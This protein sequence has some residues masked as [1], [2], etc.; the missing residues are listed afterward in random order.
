MKLRFISVWICDFKSFKGSHKFPLDL[1]VGVHFVR[2]RNKD[3]KRLGSNGSGKSS[4]WDAITWCLFGRTPAGLKNPDVI[5]WGD[6]KVGP[7]VKLTIKVD[8]THYEIMRTAKP[9][10]LQ[11]DG[12]DVG[13]EAIVQLIGMSFEVMTNTIILGQEQPLFF[14]R[15]ASEKMALLS[16]V[17]GLERWD[18]RSK[19]ASAR[20][21]ELDAELVVYQREVHGLESSI[22]EL[23]M[24]TKTLTD[25]SD[26]WQV[27]FEKAEVDTD[28]RERKLNTARDTL[29]HLVDGLDLK[30]D[31][32]MT[33]VRSLE[34]EVGKLSGQRSNAQTALFTCRARREQ[35]DE[36]LDR[37]EDELEGLERSPRCPTC[38][39]ALGK[40]VV[41]DMRTRKRDVLK[42]LTAERNELGTKKLNSE[43]EDT[44][45]R[46]VSAQSYLD[47]FHAT[48]EA[49]LREHKAQLDKLSDIKAEIKQ[50]Q[51]DR[52]LSKTNPYAL[53]LRKVRK[54]QA[55]LRADCAQ[56]KID[57]VS[58]TTELERTRYWV[59]GFKDIKLHILEELTQELELVTAGLLEECG[60]VRWTVKYV[61][62]RET[63]S[64]SMQRALAIMIG[65]PKS[66]GKLVR[67][68]SWSGG[69][70][71]RLR[72][73]GAL[74]LSSVLLNHAGV[75]PSIEVL[76]E[77]I[78][79]LSDVG[80]RDLC[81]LLAERARSHNRR[82]FY[83]DHTTVPGASFESVITIERDR[84]GSY[85]AGGV[86]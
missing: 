28:R 48:A 38:G 84:D 75:K 63:K 14:D 20:V 65:S 73:L 46:L 34:R 11:L 16:D 54:R 35:L 15:G 71:Q 26:A 22:G 31:S 74:S 85:V 29:Q 27:E 57:V 79:H 44:Q 19:A 80:V 70:R 6:D 36:K 7:M 47:S 39:G 50:L 86:R 83:C 4:V 72:I 52:D 1:P 40:H 23:I 60:L 51:R 30:Y 69:E 58:C 55:A 9:N 33:E 78:Q 64:G 68:E 41:S 37:L 13:P 56:A 81:E 76:D 10:T 53:Q 59:K 21:S 67:W 45:K 2:G 12:K 62:E 82:I 49:A 24:Q 32:A 42:E 77:P 5:S 8:D 66:K 18:A 25:Q 61:I 3:E 17:K 43:L